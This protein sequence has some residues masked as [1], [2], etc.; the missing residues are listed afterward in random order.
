MK[1]IATIAVSA[2][3]L[4]GIMTGSAVAGEVAPGDVKFDDIM[5][6]ASLTGVAGNPESGA[7]V[8]KNRKQGN[9]LACH[10]NA[11]MPKQSFQGEVGPT[12]D[13]VAERYDAET[14]RGILVNS[15]AV[16]GDGTIMP[17][18][19]RVMPDENRVAKKFNGKTILTAQQVEDVLAYLQTLK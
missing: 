2:L 3:A 7:K 17:A 15:K 1:K 12:M 13:G 14:L 16:F 4:A 9:C 5:V 19:Y 18:F 10:T 11:D 8:F 6:K